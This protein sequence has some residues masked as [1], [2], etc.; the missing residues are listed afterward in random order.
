MGVVYKAEDV[1][2]GRTVALKFL[3]PHLVSDPL[4]RR[5]F[6]REARAAASLD[7]PNICTIHEI[8][9]VDGETFLAM[10]LIEGQSLED[11]IE[12][13]PLPLQKA[14]DIARQVTEGLQAAHARRVVHRDIKPG[15]ILV[16]PEGRA[17]ILDFGLALLAAGSKLTKLDTTVGTASYMSPEQVEGLEVDLRTDLWALGCV[18][19]EIVCGRQAFKGIYGQASYWICHEDPEPL[20]ALRTGVPIELD[21][22]VSKCL[23]LSCVS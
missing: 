17:E 10:S 13:G 6:E 1:K 11:R 19:Y 5:R 21:L 18:L 23:V 2:L 4:I 22:L 20:T 7:H 12:K 15:N 14:V 8:D 16:T 9:E 3:A